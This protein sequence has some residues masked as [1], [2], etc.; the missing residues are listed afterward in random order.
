MSRSSQY[1]T[2]GQ[3]NNDPDLN[4]N[5]KPGSRKKPKSTVTIELKDANHLKFALKNTRIVVV[6]AEAGWCEPCKALQP[7]YEE[8]AQKA[9]TT[10]EFTFFTDDIDKDS[11]IHASKVT[12]VPAFFVYTDGDMNPKKQFT[13]DFDQL[14]DLI[15]RIMF[16]MR[17]DAAGDAP[18]PKQSGGEDG[19]S[20][21]SHDFQQQP[22]P[23]LG[24]DAAQP[25][26]QPQQPPPQPPPQ[27]QQ[28]PSKAS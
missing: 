4:P 21:G 18:N 26:Q 25:P 19:A 10:K 11:S 15:N 14:E 8:L 6:K 23:P 16:R 13:G 7:K 1:K 24:N 27:P 9:C 3:M 12:A 5:S 22:W 20:F 28:P 2:W 17:Q